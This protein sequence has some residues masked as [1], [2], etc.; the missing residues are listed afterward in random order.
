MKSYVINNNIEV[1]MNYYEAKYNNYDNFL[2]YEKEY[3]DFYE[4]LKSDNWKYFVNKDIKKDKELLKSNKEYL[5]MDMSIEDKKN[6]SRN[7]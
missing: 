2:E 3:N 7:I 6:R 4:N 1:I 5:N